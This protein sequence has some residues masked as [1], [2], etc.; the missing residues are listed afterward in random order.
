MHYDNY[1]YNQSFT[2]MMNSFF[3]DIIKKVYAAMQKHT[4]PMRLS[5]DGVS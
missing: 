5:F 2:C 3:I 1:K 4:I